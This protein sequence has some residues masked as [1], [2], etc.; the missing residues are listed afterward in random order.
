MAYCRFCDIHISGNKSLMIRHS[1][2]PKKKTNIKS[3]SKTS[4]I[5]KMFKA[6]P[7]FFLDINLT[8]SKLRI[9][10]YSPKHNLPLDITKTKTWSLV[11]TWSA[12][13]TKTSNF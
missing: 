2:K 7:K 10:A 1:N 13:F 12:V 11:K 9:Y 5:S 3:K 4:N 8:E 6:D